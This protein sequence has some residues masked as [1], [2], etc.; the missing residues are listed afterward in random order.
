MKMIAAAAFATT[1]LFGV[2][3]GQAHAENPTVVVQEGETVY[4]IGV[5]LLG[6]ERAWLTL[7]DLNF[8]TLE[9]C[10]RVVPGDRLVLPPKAGDASDTVGSQ[11]DRNAEGGGVE[12]GQA[13]AAEPAAVEP[14][15]AEVEEAPTE[16]EGASEEPAQETASVV[17]EDAANARQSE[18]VVEETGTSIDLA[19]DTLTFVFSGEAYQG[20][21]EY[22]IM[23][24]DAE[25]VGVVDTAIDTETEGRLSFPI[26]AAYLFTL[27]LQGIDLSTVDEIEVSFTNDAWGGPENPQFDRNL[28]LISLSLNGVDYSLKEAGLDGASPSL[29]DGVLY[30]RRNASVAITRMDDDW[31]Q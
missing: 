29:R 2:S 17:E 4:S 12:E 16:E 19:G 26:D 21:P 30:F 5:R 9:E 25:Y 10:A 22:R 31:Y 27:P 3:L 23:I 24:G 18:A 15:T 7:C 13:E 8:D 11:E 28:A 14:P 1:A 20:D 6:D